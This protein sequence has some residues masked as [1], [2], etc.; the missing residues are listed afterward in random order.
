MTDTN[1]LSRAMHDVGLAAW[2]G[3][4]LMG[5]VG[6]NGATG[7]ARDPQ[8]RTRLSS[9]GWAKWTP[10]QVAAVGVHAIG[11]LGLIGGNKGR[12]TADSDT[13]T[14]T[15]VKASLT[16][17]AA[18]V[19]AYS[20]MLGR[21]VAMH[22]EEGAHGATEPSQVASDELASAQKQLKAAQWAIPALTGVLV[23]LG[24]QQGEQQRDTRGL[25]D[26]F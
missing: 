1:T 15:A 5:A 11:G 20:G 7:Q 9:L 21:K 25:L 19:T 6:L 24:A 23:V 3:G 14:N 12:L 8:E 16:V 10:V 2:F 26:I 18:A 22:Q 13:K 17:V 4:S